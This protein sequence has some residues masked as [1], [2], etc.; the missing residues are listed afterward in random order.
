MALY[1]TQPNSIPLSGGAVDAFPL[2]AGEALGGNKAVYLR[3]DGKIYLA[4]SANPNP[5][6]GLTMSSA[7]Q[8]TQVNVQNGGELMFNGLLSGKFYYL[9]SLGNMSFIPPTTGYVQRLGVATSNGFLV[10]IGPV[11]ALAT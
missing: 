7:S 6:I 9:T 10:S 3:P 2:L 1:F 5:V 8:D 11:V 4:N